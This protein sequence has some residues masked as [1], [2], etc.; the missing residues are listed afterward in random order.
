MDAERAVVGGSVLAMLVVIV[1]AGPVIPMVE[2]PSGESGENLSMDTDNAGVGTPKLA[3]FSMQSVPSV[4]TLER[5]NGQYQTAE[6]VTLEVQAN[7]QAVNVT[8]KVVADD[9]LLTANASVGE[10]EGRTVELAPAG[11]VGSAPSEA[12]LLVTV[13]IRDKSYVTV[14]R[15][16]EIRER[17]E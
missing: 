13:E 9:M 2:L 14:N 3:A 5:K 17:D 6:V 16:V 8:T 12:R 15:T 11:S 1:L 4:L 7:D 10:G